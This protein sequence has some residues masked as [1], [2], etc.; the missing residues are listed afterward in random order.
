MNLLDETVTAFK[1]ESYHWCD[2]QAIELNDENGKH[3][4]STKQFKE[5]AA[6]D[7]DNA[8]YANDLDE[9]RRKTNVKDMVVFMNDGSFFERVLTRDDNHEGWLDK[10]YEEWKFV[11]VKKPSSSADDAVDKLYTKIWEGEQPATSEEMHKPVPTN[12]LKYMNYCLKKENL[13]LSSVVF[14]DVNKVRISVERFK[15][16]ANFGY[17]GEAVRLIRLV[18]ETGLCFQN[19]HSYNNEEYFYL[20][21][22]DAFACCEKLKHKMRNLLAQPIQDDKVTSL[23]TTR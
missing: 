1:K 5:L 10:F 13:S 18:F 2:I 6:F 11:K 16:L 12:F 21:E 14:I 19:I 4:I 22:H 17:N 8:V 7:Y 9:A 3:H 23:L 20:S 15:E